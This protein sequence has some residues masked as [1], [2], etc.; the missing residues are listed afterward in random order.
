[1]EFS[2][3]ELDRII[4][5]L[6]VMQTAAATSAREKLELIILEDRFVEEKARLKVSR[7][8][9]QNRVQDQSRDLVHFRSALPATSV[10]GMASA[11]LTDDPSEATCGE[12]R[13]IAFKEVN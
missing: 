12:C 1:M 11:S 3:R 7:V 10:C 9:N 13:T 8:G 5:S 6:V 2:E 4:H